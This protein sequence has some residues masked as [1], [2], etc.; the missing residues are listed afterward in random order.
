MVTITIEI[1][2]AIA[3]GMNQRAHDMNVD[4]D[5]AYAA[6]LAPIV[7]GVRSR[8]HTATMH[9]RIRALVTED[10]WCDAEIAEAMR[11]TT[12]SVAMIRR[13]MGLPANRR[14]WKTR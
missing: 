4:L 9:D 10:G 11:T 12:T 13:S 7:G 2:A 1:P 3:L 8:E 6:A 5:T 14:K